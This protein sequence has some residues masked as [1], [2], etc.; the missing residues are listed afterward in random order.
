VSK[1]EYYKLMERKRQEALPEPAAPASDS[2]GE[3]AAGEGA[4]GGAA[5]RSLKEKY[6]QF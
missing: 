6:D 5:K 4:A 2:E 1:D 3:P